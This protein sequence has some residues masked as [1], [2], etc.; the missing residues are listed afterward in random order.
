MIDQTLSAEFEI[1]I[2]VEPD[3]VL[4]QRGRPEDIGFDL[5]ARHVTLETQRTGE[6]KT[7]M[8]DFGVRVEP[9]KGYYVELIPRSSLAWTGFIMPN[10]VGVIDP[11]YRGI[12][13]MPLIYLG[14]IEQAEYKAQEFVGRRLA[15]LV[16][17]RHYPAQLHLAT[18]DWLCDTQRGEA[19]FGSSGH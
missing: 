10:S 11:E 17:R 5:T 12:I 6:M 2:L 16:L 8:V 15:Q 1:K 9:P 7:F 14:D 13:M 18:S 4:P 3:G 19:G